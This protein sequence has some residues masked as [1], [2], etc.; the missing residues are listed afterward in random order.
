MEIE[1]K[2]L[3]DTLPEDL[4]QYP[5]EAIEQAYLSA[6]PAVRVRRA[7]ARYV[8]TVKGEGTLSREEAEFPLSEASYI[9]LYAKAEGQPMRK[10]RYRIPWEGYVVE[11]DVFAPPFAPLVYAE[12][13]F[14]TEDAAR[15][16]V[17]P[18]WFGREV[19]YD[20]RYTNAA[21]CLEGLPPDL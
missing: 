4:E 20:W 9:Q 17:P 16:F 18:D 5:R 6:D 12:V 2:F 10:T 21:L 19:T 15:A 3:V 11:V 13:E 1:R 7:G 8:L 14:P